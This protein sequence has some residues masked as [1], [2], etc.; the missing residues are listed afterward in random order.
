[1]SI[2]LDNAATTQLSPEVWN[3]ME[4]FFKETFGNPSSTHAYGRKAKNAIEKSRKEIAE[5]LQIVPGQI[6]FTGSGSEANNTALINAVI[7]LGITHL[8]TSPIEHHAV[9]HTVDFLKENY[10]IKVTYVELDANGEINLS[11][12]SSIIKSS[13]GQKTMVTLMHVNNEIGLI[14]PVE[15]I[16]EMCRINNVLFHCDMVQSI[17]SIPVNLG[18]LPIDFASCSAHKFHGPKGTGFLYAKNSHLVKPLIHGGAQERGHR[19]GTENV[20]GIIGLSSALKEALLFQDQHPNYIRELRNLFI[21]RVMQISD[22]IK[23]VGSLDD[24]RS[25]PKILNLCFPTDLV[26]D[27]FLF[28]LD[29]K[30]IA[31]S[32]G[33]AC[34]SGS[35][36][37]SHV[38]NSIRALSNCI[39]V[40]FSF[41]KYT[42]SDEI[43]K[44]IEAIQ[45]IIKS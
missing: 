19:A 20:A 45:S 21:S 5:M 34:S 26:D 35:N 36:Q 43:E 30:G 9:L 32:G 23:V 24:H 41:S 8:I 39:A 14:T 16:G 15:Q 31:A 13:E 12:L 18:N 10:S 37:G 42:T 6:I 1:M 38:I 25:S 40:R 11:S 44:V 29:L 3:A 22:R 7:H 28:N 17:G 4:P 33:S 2:Y 27:M